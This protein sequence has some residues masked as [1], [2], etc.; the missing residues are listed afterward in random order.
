MTAPGPAAMILRPMMPDDLARALDWAAAEGWNPGWDDAGA[1]R[2]AD[3]DGFFVAEIGGAPVAAIAVVNHDDRTAF[4]GLYLCH[5]DW[6]GRGVGRA[7]WRHALAHAGA[8]TIGLDGVEAQQANYAR[9]GFVRQGATLRWQGGLAASG[10][11]CRAATPRDA[12]ALQALDRAANGYAR[13]AFLGAWIRDAPGRRTVQRDGPAGPVGFATARLCR[14]GTKIGPIIAPDAELALALAQDAL[15]AVG[16]PGPV[17]ID[18]PEANAAL[19]A[20][21]GALGFVPTF[22]TARMWR[23]TA[24]AAGPGLQAVATLELG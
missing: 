3:P 18:V 15:A 7:L 23:G 22:A 10:G 14:A 16:G 1:F 20:R 19:A 6:R 5:P 13:D 4:L 21:L 17:F 9:E 24:P 12:P 2:P 8:R 11:E